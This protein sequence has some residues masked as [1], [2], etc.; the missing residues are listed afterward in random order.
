MRLMAGQ[1]LLLRSL[2]QLVAVLLPRLLVRP[3][4]P[5]LPQQSLLA[6]HVHSPAAGPATHRCQALLLLLLRG[7]DCLKLA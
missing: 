5:L 1:L 7:R 6:G 2:P 3:E 4:P